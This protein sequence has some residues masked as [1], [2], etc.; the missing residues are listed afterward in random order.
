MFISGLQRKRVAAC[1]LSTVWKTFLSGVGSFF[2]FFL[3]LH[4]VICVEQKANKATHCVFWLNYVINNIAKSLLSFK[5]PPSR[6]SPLWQIGGPK[7][8]NGSNKRVGAEDYWSVIFL[9]HFFLPQN[10]SWNQPFFSNNYCFWLRFYL[11]CA[12]HR[13]LL[14]IFFSSLRVKGWNQK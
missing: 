13:G 9:H 11:V 1:D 3:K 12:S 5:P 4:F 8:S 6:W 14:F 10:S 2:P 7:A